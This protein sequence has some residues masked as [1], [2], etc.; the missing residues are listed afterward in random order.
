MSDLS[1]YIKKQLDN[2]KFR[3]LYEKSEGEYQVAR[4]IIKA[5]VERQMTQ[6]RQYG[7]S[8]AEPR[9]G[10]AHPKVR[11]TSAEFPV[12]IESKKQDWHHKEPKK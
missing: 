7:R 10:I 11:H 2:P 12:N 5:R 9:S 1:V 6:N 3:K 8:S 4:E